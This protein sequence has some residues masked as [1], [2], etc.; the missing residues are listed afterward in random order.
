[1]AD[2]GKA[3][4]QHVQEEP[5]DELFA[6]QRDSL[7]LLAAIAAVVDRRIGRMVDPSQRDLSRIPSKKLNF[8]LIW[9]GWIW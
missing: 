6:A 7:D 4:W 5:L 3:A 8:S 2:F 1:M 9:I